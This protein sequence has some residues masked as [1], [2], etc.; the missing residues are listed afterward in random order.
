M[1]E[2]TYLAVDL[3]SFYASAECVSRGLDPLDTNL[4]VADVSRTSKTICLAVSPALKALGIGS[5]ARLFEVEERVSAVNEQRRLRAPGRRLTGSS[6]SASALHENSCLRV[7]FIAA[8]PR[9]S[10]YLDMSAKIYGIYLNYAS[11]DD[12][13]VYSV[14]EVFIDVTRYLRYFGCPAHELARRIVADVLEQTGITA[15]AGIGSNLYLA[16]VAM[17]IVSKHIP[18]DEDGVRIAELDERR[19]RELLWSHRPLTDFWR[20]GRGIARKLERQGIMTMGDIARC[21]L[22]RADEYYNED[23]LYRFFGVNAETLID[24]AWG[25][26]PCTIADIKAYA[27]HSSSVSSGQVLARPYPHDQAH[28]V[29]CEMADA[30]A[31][32]LVAKQMVTDQV[33]LSVDFDGADVSDASFR[34]RLGTD[35]YGRTVPKSA[36]GSEG[37]GRFTASA[38]A[39]REAA[40]AIFERIADPHLHVRR[41]TIAA[42]HVR[43]EGIREPF[44]QP[45]LF[46]SID[47]GNARV[48]A[49]EDR[50]ELRLQQ[51]VNHVRERFGGASV[52]KGMNFDEGA[53]GRERSHQIGGHAS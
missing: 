39:M 21:S 50:K 20:V 42:N 6:T 30:L 11:K 3:K 32:D 47:K 44:E 40:A 24:H 29:V 19:Y 13:H 16:K 49:V 1:G 23:L 53:T 14:D 46:E 45:D 5:R 35:H 37:L 12:I 8:K 43:G 4:V 34:G 22:G 10:Y 48:A 52:L 17:D 26:E 7:D 33:A 51:A 36:H 15:T 2:R 41:I 18:A 27:P 31:Q 28:T 25:W 9:M 38:T